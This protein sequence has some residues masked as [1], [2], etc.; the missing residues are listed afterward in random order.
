MIDELRKI[1]ALTLGQKLL[2]TE[3]NIAEESAGEDG[4]NALLDGE[5][6][7]GGAPGRASCPVV[8]QIGHLGALEASE[9]RPVRD[10][11]HVAAV[12]QNVEREAE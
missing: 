4:L 6:V 1:E 12:E 3:H 8:R 7:D 10:L 9:T 11:V 2:S 5:I